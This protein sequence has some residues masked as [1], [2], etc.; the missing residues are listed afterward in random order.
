MNVKIFVLLTAVFTISLS[1][2]AQ[3][4]RALRIA[5]LATEK[6]HADTDKEQVWSDKNFDALLTELHVLEAHGLN[7]VHY[8]IDRLEA[9]KSNRAARDRL[10]TAAW[11]TAASHMLYGKLDPVS[12]EP[13]WTAASRQ[14]DLPTVLRYTLSSGTIAGSLEQ[15]APIQPE[16]SALKA[17][18][19]RLRSE[20]GFTRIAVPEGPAL[21]PGMTGERVSALQKRL[22]Q[23]GLLVA[24]GE[25]GTFDD[26]TKLSLQTFQAANE[27]DND[28]VAGAASVRALNR[29]PEEKIDQVRVNMER[30]RW[31][32]G[33]LGRRHLRANIAGFNVTAF[34][35]GE[36]QETHLTIVGKT[37]RKTPVFTDEIEYIIFNPWWETP[38]SLARADKLPLF[39]KDSAAV[40][41]MGFEV[42]DKSGARIN[43]SEIDWTSISAASF[44]YRLRQAPGPQNAL[45]Q[46]K[47]M[48]P[49]VHNV[50][51]HDTPTR[52]LF[53]SQQR[54]FSSGC[55]RTQD[56][57]GLSKWLL[58]DTVGWD[59]HRID[60]AVTSG[61]ETRATLS[62]KIPVHIL[63]NTVVSG[64]AAGVRYLD[65][66][67][68]RDGRVLNGLQL[69]PESPATSL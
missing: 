30:W 43:A 32:P 66:I 22:I 9:L 65:D 11:F 26:A 35:N 53:A 29:G 10:A 16:Y 6:F 12:V 46:V 47:I 18:L 7:P 21:K 19:A 41:R 38:P 60:A 14:A 27:L 25:S 1:A 4:D 54:A 39:Q 59:A 52:G 34:E 63:Y 64:G 8:R 23:L 57:V 33:D 45:G 50:Y 15:F 61:K 49:N 2:S 20:G 62:E 51:L 69:S 40:A 68:S 55:L 58:K 44:P 28:G 48:F 13:D 37:Y 42:L 3:I 5:P 36:P 67:Y 17:E 24:A 31:L 56:P